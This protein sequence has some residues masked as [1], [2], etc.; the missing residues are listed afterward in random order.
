MLFRSSGMSV[1]MSTKATTQ[2]LTLKLLEVSQAVDMDLTDSANWK[3]YVLLNQNSLANNT[4][5]N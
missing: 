4:A 5:G 3:L 1:D 2:A